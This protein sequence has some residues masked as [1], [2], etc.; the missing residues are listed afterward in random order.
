MKMNGF[1][2]SEKG[3]ISQ[4]IMT[5]SNS[6]IISSQATLYSQVE[7]RQFRKSMQEN[8]KCLE[9][10][11]INIF[12]SRLNFLVFVNFWKIVTYYPRMKQPLRMDFYRLNME[13][14]GHQ[15]LLYQIIQRA[16]SVFNKQTSKRGG[17][18]VKLISLDWK[19]RNLPRKAYDLLYQLDKSHSWY[20]VMMT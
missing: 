13:I 15:S 8:R 5:S 9:I 12:F 2:T 19:V 3:F 1:S 16:T 6:N 10:T 11:K 14:C 20:T 4:M 17:R 18:L 7:F